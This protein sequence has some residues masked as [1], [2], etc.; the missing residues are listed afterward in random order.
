MSIPKH[1]WPWLGAVSAAVVAG[2][3][4]FAIAVLTKEQK[5]SEFR[6]AWIDALR[7]D[8]AN[9]A[10]LIDVL[11][12]VVGHKLRHG[13]PLPAIQKGMLEGDLSDFKAVDV[14]RLRILF[15]LNPK[16]H[17]A[18]IRLVNELH[19]RS[20]VS[21]QESP[22]EVSRL[23]AQYSDEVQRV[24]KREWKRVKRGEPIFRV[25][26]WLSLAMFGV[27]VGLGAWLLREVLPD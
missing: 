12:D 3:I 4:S 2:S 21:E 17:A 16:E 26:K 10:A 19:S 11:H 14:T 20:A 18:L 25:T 9:Y 27:A 1:A 6:Q 24:L 8:L 13:H 15:R 5:T 7:E 23:I 22:G